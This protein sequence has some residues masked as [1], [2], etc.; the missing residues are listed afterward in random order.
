[1]PKPA[2]DLTIDVK[3]AETHTMPPCQDNVRSPLMPITPVTPV[4]TQGLASLHNTVMNQ[5][6]QGLDEQSLVSFQKNVEKITKAAKMAI[7]GGILQRDRIYALMK[8]NDESKVRRSTKA[9][10]L[11]KAKVMGYDEVVAKRAAVAAAEAAQAIKA[12][13]GPAKRGRK[14]K[15]AA[16]EEGPQTKTAKPRGESVDNQ[17]ASSYRAPVATMVSNRAI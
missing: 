5:A 6:A 15:R 4:T 17:V 7:A 8:A 12:A 16:D 3:K 1:M 10:V 11:G 14:R 13:Q 9:V 2:Q